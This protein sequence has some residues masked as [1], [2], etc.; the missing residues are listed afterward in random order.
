MSK[1]SPRTDA[2][3]LDADGQRTAR[4]REIDDRLVEL[5][6]EI[7]KLLAEKKAI[8]AAT[9]GRDTSRL[10]WST[11]RPLARPSA[12][13]RVYAELGMN[14]HADW[15]NAPPA[16]QGWA[17]WEWRAR[18]F[19]LAIR[20]HERAKALGGQRSLRRA[21][22]DIERDLLSEWWEQGVHGER[23]RAVSEDVFRARRRAYLAR[24]ASPESGKLKRLAS[25][26]YKNA[27]AKREEVESHLA[28]LEK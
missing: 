4:L 20:V 2:T 13:Y 6:A 12:L 5:R 10:P 21:A 18:E 19:E 28:E 7:R 17:S 23:A 15:A 9:K 24:E 1:D 25:A 22:R 14:W 16:A 26:L 11:L 3:V 27:Y 8:E